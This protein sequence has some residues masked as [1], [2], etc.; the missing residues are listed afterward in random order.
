M[1]LKKKGFSYDRCPNPVYFKSPLL[2]ICLSAI[3]TLS[4]LEQIEFNRVSFLRFCTKY[5]TRFSQL[6]L[7]VALFSTNAI[8]PRKSHSPLP[9]NIQFKR[10]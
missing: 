5:D 1:F 4:C 9:H 10:P 6:K 2:I 8:N 7:I 3:E